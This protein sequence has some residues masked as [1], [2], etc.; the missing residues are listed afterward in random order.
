MKANIKQ[1]NIFTALR[2]DKMLVIIMLL[3]ILLAAC[4]LS[5][6]LF[7]DFQY[8]AEF[9]AA[10][11]LAIALLI[12]LFGRRG[13]AFGFVLYACSL[14]YLNTFYN[15]GTIFFLLIAYG[16]Y[17]RIKWTAVIV[18]TLN[19]FIS[20]SLQK[21]IPISIL[22][23]FVYLG[24]FILITL[25]VYKVKPSKTLNLKEDERHILDQL[26]DGKLQK[27]IEGYS[28]QTI[29]AKLKNAK[30]RNMCESTT[31]LLTMYMI[32]CGVKIGKCG[33]PCKKNCP[34]RDSCCIEKV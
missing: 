29:T 3:H 11:C 14:I 19:V 1:K 2:N 25:S 32:E 7:S 20:F 18:Y 33:K 24:L 9:R 8:H 16:A 4:H 17:P 27:E 15:Y 13:M 26:M 34:K 30:E 23:H 21:L 12:L 28:Q 10:G 6:N 31:D 22:I 5:F